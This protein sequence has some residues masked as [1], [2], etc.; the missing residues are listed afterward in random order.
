MTEGIHDSVFN[1]ATLQNLDSV[2]TDE[3]AIIEVEEDELRQIA[4]PE[5]RRR[6]ASLKLASRIV[7]MATAIKVDVGEEELLQSMQSTMARLNSLREE[8]LKHMGVERTSS[9]YRAIFNSVTHAMLDVL[10]EEW[11]WTKLV[12]AKAVQLEAEVVARL[13]QIVMQSQPESFDLPSESTPSIN[14]WRHLS[15][16]EIVSRLYGLLNFFDYYQ[17]N[18]EAVVDCL[19]QAIIEQAELQAGRMTSSRD[20]SFVHHAILQK[21]YRISRDLMCE[22][23][24]EMATRDVTRLQEMQPLDRSVMILRY[25]QIGMK[26]DHIIET[27]RTAMAHVL[28]TTQVI[29]EKRPLSRNFAENSHGNK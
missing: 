21:M 20:P 8:V 4:N 5:A 3:A 22:V 25:E 1:P 7:G 29:L 14:A 17:S 10:T 26:Y 16:L 19:M 2:L 6:C 28:E 9:D 24:K 27:H 13:S 12:P 23:Y 11:K 18:R 15:L